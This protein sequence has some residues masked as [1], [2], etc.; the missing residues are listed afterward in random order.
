M[1]VRLAENIREILDA[2]TEEWGIEVTIVKLKD[3]QLPEGLKRAKI[4][5][6]EREALA[7]DRLNVHLRLMPRRSTVVQAACSTADLAPAIVAT[8]ATPSSGLPPYAWAMAASHIGYVEKESPGAGA[9]PGLSP[10]R[11]PL[12]VGG[13]FRH[14]G[15]FFGWLR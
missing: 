14:R 11:D 8:P 2:Q 12:H 7:A 15:R 9:R 13:T 1:V 6:A 10:R 5:A 3:I 4:I